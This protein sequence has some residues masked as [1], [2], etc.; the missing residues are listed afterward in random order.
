MKIYANEIEN[1]LIIS[2]IGDKTDE[3]FKFYALD[4]ILWLLITK[5]YPKIKK[6]NS[7]NS[8]DGKHIAIVEVGD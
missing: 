8:F 5:D 4:N 6:I 1:K 3:P 7:N 2:F